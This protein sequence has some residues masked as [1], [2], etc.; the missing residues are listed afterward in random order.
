MTVWMES[1]DGFK[2]YIGTR[3]QQDLMD[4]QMHRKTLIAME[5]FQ[6]CLP[7]LASNRIIDLK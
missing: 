3:R 2:I 7:N 1:S 6:A 5:L 4:D